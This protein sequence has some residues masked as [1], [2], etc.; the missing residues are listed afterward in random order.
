MHMR[1]T[2][3]K[4]A[5][6]AVTR[7][8]LAF[9]RGTPGMHCEREQNTERASCIDTDQDQVSRTPTSRIGHMLTR[10]LVSDSKGGV[11][12]HHADRSAH[13]RAQSSCLRCANPYGLYHGYCDV[14]WREN[15]AWQCPG[16]G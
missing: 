16:T 10:P 1:C 13:L 7:G 12:N 11:G 4:S 15:H 5:Y 8:V 14:R 2:G 9:W 6:G 3:G